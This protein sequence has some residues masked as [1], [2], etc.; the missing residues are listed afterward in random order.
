MEK[1]TNTRLILLAGLDQ[2]ERFALIPFFY[3]ERFGGLLRKLTSPPYPTG[4]PYLGPVFPHSDEWGTSR[5]E[6]RV[7]DF[8]NSLQEYINSNIKPHSVVISTSTKL[9]DVRPFL[10]SGYDVLPRYTY[11]GDI[12]LQ[13]LV[14]EKFNSSTRRSIN[15]A[16]KAALTIEQGDLKDYIYLINS[17]AL[18][19]EEQGKELDLPKD[20]LID[21]FNR[22]YPLQLKVFVC[23]YEGDVIGG[24]V[25]L[26][27]KD[28]I[29]FWLGGVR[30]KIEK[31]NVNAFVCWKIIQWATEHQIKYFDLF[32]ANTPS[33]SSFKSQFGFDLKTFFWIRK[34]SFR[35]KIGSKILGIH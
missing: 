11:I 8:Q 16:E 6:T 5:W 18:R 19:Y 25:V 28:T 14:W 35:H 2:D 30:P 31:I 20:Y 7:V 1:H 13:S 26:M 15:K 4:V 32:G 22:F 9:S 29:H 27:H 10:W 21:V 24:Q 34:S 23:R 12:S 3:E 17:L 33:I